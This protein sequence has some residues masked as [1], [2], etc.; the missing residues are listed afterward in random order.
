MAVVVISPLQAQLLQCSDVQMFN[1]DGD[2]DVDVP[3][4]NDVGAERDA[5]CGPRE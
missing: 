4:S 5:S 1:L 2:V 3:L